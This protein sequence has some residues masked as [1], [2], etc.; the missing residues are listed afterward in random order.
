MTHNKKYHTPRKN[1][2]G[3]LS[4]QIERFYKKWG[5]DWTFNIRQTKPWSHGNDF[6]PTDKELRSDSLYSRSPLV[7]DKTADSDLEEMFIGSMK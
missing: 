1:I 2:M 5:R 3:Y 4:P 7:K 6:P